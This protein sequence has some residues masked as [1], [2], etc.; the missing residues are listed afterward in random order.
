MQPTWWSVIIQRLCPGWIA[1]VLDD[2]AFQARTNLA[3]CAVARAFFD[4]RE[5]EPGE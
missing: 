2:W 3:S 5:R 4:Y 1:P